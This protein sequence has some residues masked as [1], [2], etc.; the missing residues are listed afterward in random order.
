MSSNQ[1]LPPTGRAG[2]AERPVIGEQEFGALVVLIRNNQRDSDRLRII[3]NELVSYCFTCAQAAALLKEIEFQDAKAEAAVRLFSGLVDRE[4]FDSVVLNALQF[5]EQRQAVRQQVGYVAVPEKPAVSPA[6]TTTFKS[7]GES[8][9][10]SS[11]LQ[12]K[13]AKDSDEDSD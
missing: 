6:Q 5:D 7:S 11:W 13:P 2:A 4:Q 8:K 10:E 1:Y 3:R 9:S 12:R